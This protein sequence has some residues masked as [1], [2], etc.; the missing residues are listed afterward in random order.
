MKIVSLQAE[1]LKRLVAV[2]IKPDGAL[3]EITG[4]N[5]QGKTSVLDAIWWALEGTS[6]IQAAPIRKGATEAF[7]RLDLG[8]L[9]V[10]RTFS[11]K[12]QGAY[13]TKL[14]VEN[15]EGARFGS[16]QN[17]LDALVGE[18]TFDP[19]EF[20][21]KK[22]KE[23]FDALK[24]FV[25]GV[26]FEAMAEAD[27]ADFATRTDVNRVAKQL[28]AQIDGL[29]DDAD[30]DGVLADE[31]ALVAKLE[32]AGA[33]NADVERQRAAR[34]TYVQDT[35]RL[36]QE[37]IAKKDQVEALRT[38]LAEAEDA[39]KSLDTRITDRN[40][41]ASSA[42]ALPEPIVT[43]ELS[44]QIAGARQHNARVEAAQR[45]KADRERLTAEA[46]KHEAQSAALTTAMAE[47]AAA[48]AKAIGAASMPVPGLTFGDGVVLLNG[49]PFDQGSDAEQLRASI[50]IAAAM[51]PRL[52]VVRVRDGSLLDQEAMAALAQFA[53]EHDL[54]VWCETVSS[55]RPSA[56]LIEDGHVAG[57][58]VPSPA[59]TLHAAE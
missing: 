28:R 29:G 8:K 33:H 47:R 52:R 58:Q 38:Q 59:Q 21:R 39:A 15:E 53:D 11:A 13:T 45:I 19:L 18:L 37:W 41:K 16:P 44:D 57:Q 56:V 6:H 36:R 25:P 34:E 7:I 20:A 54:Q 12:E 1:N 50:A 51:N 17:M 3:V 5:G 35:E 23:Q 4:R 14:F 32:E 55:G 43:S 22:P 30:A 31:R 10:T 40:Q 9:K 24:G 2:E 48:K 46:E 42:A 49:V 26:D 27:R